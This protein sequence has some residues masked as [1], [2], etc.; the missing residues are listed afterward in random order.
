MYEYLDLDGFWSCLASQDFKPAQK[1]ISKLLTYKKMDG[2]LV[3]ILSKLVYAE[4]IHQSCAYYAANTVLKIQT[5]YNSYLNVDRDVRLFIAK[6]H[7]VSVELQLC[8]AIIHVCACRALM[9][10]ICNLMSSK[11]FFYSNGSLE[12]AEFLNRFLK[13]E[14]MIPLGPFS[15]IIL[16][17]SKFFFHFIRAHLASNNHQ[18]SESTINLFLAKKSLMHS[19]RH[20]V[21]QRKL[22][23]KCYLMW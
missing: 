13:Q 18:I 10:S 21:P 12:M 3:G 17:E 23:V 4:S 6:H 5:V 7:S 22:H 14:Q 19:W 11:P 16:S 8:E 2:F 15:E 1:Y 9:I 20:R